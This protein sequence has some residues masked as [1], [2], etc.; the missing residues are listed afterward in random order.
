MIVS[1]YDHGWQ[2]YDRE[3]FPVF[4]EGKMREVSPDFIDLWFDHFRIGTP[5][6]FIRR[7]EIVYYS[8]FNG[9]W[10]YEKILSRGNKAVKFHLDQERKLTEDAGKTGEITYLYN[11]FAPAAFK[12]SGCY[13][14]GGMQYQDP[15]DSRYDIISFLTPPFEKDSLIKGTSELD[16]HVKST[17]PDTCFYV[18]LSIVREDGTLVLRDD[19]DSLCRTNPDYQPGETAVLHFEFTEHC[20]AV[21]KGEQLRLDVSSSCVPHFLVHT[22]RKGA[23][24][25][26]TGADTAWNTICTGKSVLTLYLD[27]PAG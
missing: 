6:K 17:A 12:G 11:P 16:L 22:N 7:G 19:I 10:R 23:M 21:K 8:M 2:G 20:Y 9:P 3:G 1:P 24:A 15:P 5:L 27:E 14:F 25:E 18:R 26:Q 13:T 4:P